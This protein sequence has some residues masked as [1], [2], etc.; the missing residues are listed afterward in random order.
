[1]ESFKNS[2]KA[3]A[4]EQTLPRQQHLLRSLASN[5]HHPHVE[6]LIH[7]LLQQ[8]SLAADLLITLSGRCWLALANID[9]L[10]AFFEHLVA[11]EDQS[12][13]NGIFKDLVAIPALR[14]V[15]FQCMR[16]P[17]RSEA[18]SKAIGHLFHQA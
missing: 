7:Q 2:L 5:C 12:L 13:F 6:Q 16:A 14:P 8:Q 10:M 9:N 11:C 1:I 4:N 17:E 3:T 15:V 18:L